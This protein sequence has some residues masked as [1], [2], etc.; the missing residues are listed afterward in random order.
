M[1]NLVDY[2]ES[3]PESIIA[4]GIGSDFIR[5]E[6]LDKPFK[7]A[8]GKRGSYLLEHRWL[9]CECQK[10]TDQS[11]ACVQGSEFT[12]WQQ[13]EIKKLLDEIKTKPDVN[14]FDHFNLF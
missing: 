3:F 8:D 1:P 13:K 5:I 12:Y 11:W 10:E 7:R 2:A 14:V 9:S 4:Q 6:R